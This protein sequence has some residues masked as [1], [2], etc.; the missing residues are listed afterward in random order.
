MER[1]AF[2][3]NSVL[4]SAGTILAPRIVNGKLW[5]SNVNL[6]II[7]CGG[8]G[9]ALISSMSQ[10]ANVNIIAMADIF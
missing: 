9:T 6:G 2:I 1:R 3:R 8:R 5:A 7:G 4:I 10:N